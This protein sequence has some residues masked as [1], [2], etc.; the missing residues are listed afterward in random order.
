[1]HISEMLKTFLSQPFSV[2]V[3][4]YIEYIIILALGKVQETGFAVFQ[5]IVDEF[6][7]DA[8]D[9]EFGL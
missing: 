5:D 6:L 3:D 4:A 1:M 8:K 7:N 2:M 9:Q